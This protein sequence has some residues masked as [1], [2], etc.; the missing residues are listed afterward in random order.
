[1]QPEDW[2]VSAIVM[3]KA[4]PNDVVFTPEPLAKM[5]IETFTPTGKCLDPCKGR[6]AFF[7]YLPEGS[8]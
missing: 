4:N 1:M 6:G 8:D 5:V 7:Q 2:S 3:F